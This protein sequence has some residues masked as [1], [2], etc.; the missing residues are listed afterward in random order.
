[1]QRLARSQGTSRDGTEAGRAAR[2]RALYKQRVS[3]GEEPG[4]D[5]GEKG[6]LGLETSKGHEGESSAESGPGVRTLPGASLQ[7]MGHISVTSM[8]GEA[9]GSQPRSPAPWWSLFMGWEGEVGARVPLRSHPCRQR[10]T[11][12][13]RAT[14]S[15]ICSPQSQ[16]CY[17]F[18]LKQKTLLFQAS[19]SKHPFKAGWA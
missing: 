14:R 11:D 15:A 12:R 19:D 18:F 17:G 8:N 2:G 13:H 5:P 10:Q 16:L 6:F 4:E 9:D 1:M 3:M 7:P